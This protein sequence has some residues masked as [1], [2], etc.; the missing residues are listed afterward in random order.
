MLFLHLQ[1]AL[2]IAK[3]IS[4]TYMQQ[5]DAFYL[6]GERRGKKIHPLSSQ[7]HLTSG[8]AVA[9][10]EREQGGGCTVARRARGGYPL[11]LSSSSSSQPKEGSLA[12]GLSQPEQQR[13]T[14]PRAL[15]ELLPARQ[16]RGR[17]VDMSIPWV[18]PGEKSC[19]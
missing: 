13:L 10:G 8:G 6:R 16:R 1:M 9:Q 17:R 4:N 12:R 18:R 2:C 11:S 15:V 14:E 3:S 19:P 5:P 7:M